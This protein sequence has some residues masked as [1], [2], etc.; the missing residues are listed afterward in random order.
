MTGLDDLFLLLAAV[1][2]ALVF[3]ARN[4]LRRDVRVFLTDFQRGIRYENGEFSGVLQPGSHVA[5]PP[6]VQI[7]SVDLRPH[8]FVIERLFF[9]DALGAPSVIS[10]SGAL[11]V[12]DPY[13]SVTAT[14]DPVK[15]SIVLVR[16]ALRATASRG[17]TDPMLVA[18]QKLA[19]QIAG[20]ANADLG[21]FGMRV[22]NL[23]VTEVWAPPA[24][25][26]RTLSEAN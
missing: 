5:V 4:R 6:L 2:A 12:A 13:L 20:A 7:V 18:R 3:V 21:R 24:P 17:V 23:E 26:P 9:Q 19:D 10:I 25:R 22:G 11:T 1:G 16:E 8:L 14:R 15:D